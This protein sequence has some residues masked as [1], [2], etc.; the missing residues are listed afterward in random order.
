[1]LRDDSSSCVADPCCRGRRAE[2]LLLDVGTYS[3]APGDITPAEGSAG[4]LLRLFEDRK[5]DGLLTAPPCVVEFFD[6][7][8]IERLPTEAAIREQTPKFKT[9]AFRG[10]E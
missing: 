3:E 1:M 10:T 8:P 6:A 4:V 9:V 2:V 5:V 7:S